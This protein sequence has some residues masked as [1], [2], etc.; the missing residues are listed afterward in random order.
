MRSLPF[1]PGEYRAMI[2][3][4]LLYAFRMLGLFMVLPVLS[5]YTRDLPG[6]TPFLVG[7]A[8]GGY[9]LTQAVLQIPFGM[10]SDRIGR[11]EVIA[12]G[13]CLFLLGSIIA[14]LS[15]S[16]YGIII[17]RCLQGSGAIA[18]ALMA[19][20]AD[21]TREEVRTSAMAAIG[22]SIGVSFALAMAIGPLLAEYFGLSG[23]F[24]STSLLA[25]AGLVILWRLVPAAPA[26]RQHR[27]VGVD[28]R[29]LIAMLR[30]P[31]LLRL[32][33]SI[34]CLHAL[35]TAAFV[36]LPLELEALGIAPRYHGWVYLPIMAL[37]FIAMLPLIIAA[38]KYRR[39]RPIFLSTVAI[40]ALSLL[41]LGV[42]EDSRWSVLALLF[43]FFTGF[44]LMEATLPSMISKIAP[45][46]AKGS[47]MGIYSTSQFLGACLGGAGG[48]AIV[49]V[50]GID[51]LFQ[52]SAL[53]ALVWFL[54]VL[55]MQPPRHLSS[56]IIA[57]DETLDARDKQLSNRLAAIAGVEEVM[58]VAQERIAYL[59]VDRDKL[60]REALAHLSRR[61]QEP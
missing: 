41:G 4:G 44:N 29:Q 20:L 34:L 45:V 14:A 23:I 9:G 33:F 52:F 24:W 59:K 36:A 25:V 58:V 42:F 46:G 2:G 37:G 31:D 28:P 19:L 13:L 30:R 51:A 60:D 53:L 27:D 18:G 32:D 55:G 11:K 49:G 47:A 17:G 12:A 22:M 3:L 7:V 57:L 16:I 48:G 43:V 35:L 5:L 6:A 40:M 56:E 1:L 38:E 54:S 61:Q 26:R 21:R 50:A 8:L 39:M 15:S 10:L